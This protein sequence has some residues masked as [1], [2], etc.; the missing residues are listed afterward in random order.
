FFAEARKISMKKP[1]VVCKQGR[2]P[3][4]RRAIQW[5]TATPPGSYA[6]QRSAFEDA[7]MICVANGVEM[8]EVA[9]ALAW[10][11]LPKG[12]RVSKTRWT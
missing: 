4:G 7:G 3:E 10:Q 5:H 6:T 8:V 9:K 12:N 2:T 11:P 1:I